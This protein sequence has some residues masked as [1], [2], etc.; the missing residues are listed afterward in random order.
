MKKM[1]TPQVFDNL[2]YIL[3]SKLQQKA[4]KKEAFSLVHYRKVPYLFK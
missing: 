4:R 1:G 3:P 2:L